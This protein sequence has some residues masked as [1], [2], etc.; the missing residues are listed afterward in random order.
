MKKPT[1]SIDHRVNAL[2][3]HG[4]ENPKKWAAVHGYEE[5]EIDATWTELDHHHEWVRLRQ[6]HLEETNFLFSML[7]AMRT[8][9]LEL[10]KE[11]EELKK[12]P[13]PDP[14]DDRYYGPKIW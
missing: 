10:Q 13:Q 3:E 4:I 7:G 12:R 14:Y 11:N 5:P 9:M 6:H 1:L 8:R 2:L